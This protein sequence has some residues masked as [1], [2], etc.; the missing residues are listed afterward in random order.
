MSISEPKIG[1]LVTLKSGGPVMTIKVIDYTRQGGC[2]LV[3]VW[4][5]KDEK[6]NETRFRSEIIVRV[7]P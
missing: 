7:K 3:C 1:E 6:L 5:T 2:E 4:F